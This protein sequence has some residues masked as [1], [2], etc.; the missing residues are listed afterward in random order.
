M[1]KEEQLLAQKEIAQKMLDL[2]KKDCQCPKVAVKLEA[3]NK[4]LDALNR[5][6]YYLRLEAIPE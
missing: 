4:A 6:A 2:V 1:T 3:L 5:A